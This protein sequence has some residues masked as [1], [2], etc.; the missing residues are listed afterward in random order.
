METFLTLGVVI[1]SLLPVMAIGSQAQATDRQ[2]HDMQDEDKLMDQGAVPV[3]D[4]EAVV[5]VYGTLSPIS[6]MEYPGQVTVINRDMIELWAPSAISDLLRDVPGVEFSGGPRRTGE[7]PSIRGR[8]GE[9]VL[10]LL[11]GARQSFI[12]AH[13]G[14]FFLDP[15]L[16]KSAEVVKGPASAL[17]GSGAVGGVLA[18]E[19]VNAGDLLGKDQTMGVRG[20]LAYQSVNDETLATAM[21]YTRQGMFDGLAAFGERRS[22]DI[23]LGSGAQLPADDDIGSV[24]LKGRYQLSPD[25]ELDASW[26]HFENS[27]FEPNNG[28]GVNGTDNDDLSVNV[29]KDSQADTYRLGVEFNPKAYD[30]LDMRLTLYRAETSVTEL[31]ESVPRT[32]KRDIETTG[33]SWRNRASLQWG[34]ESH[35]TIGA[36]WYED[37]Q[38]GRDDQA[39]NGLRSGVPNGTS[40]FIGAFVQLESRFD[41]IIGPG[42][43]VLIIPGVRFDKFDSKASGLSTNTHRDDAISPRVG[44]SLGL[45]D[46]LRIF[47]SYSKAFRAPSINELYLDGVHFNIPHPILFDADRHAFIFAPNNF[48]P[49]LD[50]VPEKS[51]TVEF[52]V[53]FD[54][55]NIIVDGDRF[56]TKGSY[57]QSAVD[58][59][60]NLSV[61]FA[62]DDS[63]F[64][65]PSFRPCTAGTTESANLNKA[66]LDGFEWEAVYNSRRLYMRAGYGAIKGEDKA[67][68]SDLGVLT[69]DRFSLD[70]RL[71]M[72]TLQAAL[73]VRLQWA[74]DFKRRQFNSI[75]QT[76]D[77]IENRESYAVGDVYATWQPAFLQGVRLDA[78]IDNLWDKN[79]ARVFEG[80][81]E[82]GRNYKL[83]AT[84]TKGW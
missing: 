21:A 62:F 47:G 5:T 56:T 70:T 24:L 58:D 74:G 78:S 34:G 75:S 12:S 65:P 79:Y 60:I 39:D 73:G 22:G 9:N 32:T 71:K 80:V 14:R 29:D 54:I 31:D 15:D 3:D 81:S 36:D 20:R 42:S 28:Q 43:D 38:R 33:L 69:P 84:W 35:L 63:C 61:N 66:D 37:R 82:P 30:W 52:G 2:D 72:P 53:S 46:Q 19:T 8:G 51:E 18:F 13:D 50:L 27:A 1:V 44:V 40:Q 64:V 76:Y 41:N 7:T 11:D 16:L 49:N 57:Y 67:D 45:N 83:A 23:A 55:D 6:V 68:G 4:D 17:Y 25:F 77:V 10:I 59:L 48:V 26:Q